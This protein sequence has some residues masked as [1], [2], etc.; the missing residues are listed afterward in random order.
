MVHMVENSDG[1]K[2]LNRQLNPLWHILHDRSG[3]LMLAAAPSVF[4]QQW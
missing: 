2:L 4:A 3:S 1:V